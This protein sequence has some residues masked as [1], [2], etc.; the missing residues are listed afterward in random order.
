MEA[1]LDGRGVRENPDVLRQILEQ[2]PVGIWTMSPDGMVLDCNPTFLRMM[3][4]TREQLLGFNVLEK[5]V[6]R[7]IV[8]FLLRALAG[9]Q[10]TTEIKYTST[11]GNRTGFY[12]CL[13][14]PILMS[15]KVS[16]V[17]SIVEDISDRERAE[18]AL[19]E[20]EAR[21]RALFES[22]HAGIVILD[23]ARIEEFNAQVSELLGRSSPGLDGGDFFSL[24]P[25]FQEN[26]GESRHLGAQIILRAYAGTPQN[27]EWRF[28]TGT[29]E[30]VPFEISLNRFSTSRGV[31][32]LGIVREIRERKSAQR[33]LE[34]EKRVLASIAAGE[35]VGPVLSDLCLVIE[36]QRPHT[37]CAVLL[38]SGN[39]LLV[40]AAPSLPE[41]YRYSI[42]GMEIGPLAA[43]SGTAAFTK[44]TVIA[45]DIDAHPAWR[46]HKHQALPYGLKA[47]WSSPIFSKSGCVLGT[48]DVYCRAPRSPDRADLEIL[49]RASH[50]A[51]IAIEKQS[52]EKALLESEERLELALKGAGLGYWDWDSRTGQIG[53][54]SSTTFLPGYSSADLPKTIEEWKS[55]LHADDWER[56]EKT[57]FSYLAGRV[58][59]FDTEFRF[60]ARNNSWIWFQVRGKVFER[61]EEGRPLRAAGTFCDIS[62]RKTAEEQLF[63]TTFFDSLTG[64][65]NRALFLDRAGVCLK[66]RLLL[67]SYLYAVLFIDIDRFKN[68]N[69]GLGHLIGDQLIQEFARRLQP[70]LHPN[71]TLARLGGD[72]FAILLDG[73]SDESSAIRMAERIL[74][75]MNEP[76]FLGG[77]YLNVTASIGIALGEHHYQG[78][79]EVL[80]DADTAMYRA[81]DAGRDTY[82]VFNAEMHRYAIDRLNLENSLRRAL[83]RKQLRL[84]YQPVVSVLERA[85][86]GFE[87][88]I[89]WQLPERGLVPPSQFIPL[90]E[91]TGL[92]VPIGQ[93]VLE[94]ACRQIR[95]LDS[96][97]PSGRKLRIN[98]NLSARQIA[99]TGFVD[100]V[101]WILRDSAIDP[102]RICLEIT[103]SVLLDR[104]EWTVSVLNRLR[105]LGVRLALDDFGTGYASLSY[106][107]RYPV[108]ELKIDRSFVSTAD[109]NERASLIART[110]VLLAKNLG[111]SVCAEGVETDEQLDWVQNLGCDSVQG[112]LFSKPVP[113]EQALVFVRNCGPAL[114]SLF[115]GR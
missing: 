75:S 107:V 13:L 112:F 20:S 31:R 39:R 93:W 30:S 104:P 2:A 95:I 60:R 21:Y 88:L 12:R 83:E 7:A 25:P 82:A 6:D 100:H 103:E 18:A 53:V 34:A 37:L 36:G 57:F 110:I 26:A 78:P 15:G 115:G 71:D 41:P 106:L 61:D 90:A 27:F 24:S 79:E 63:R 28:L 108:S 51:A 81:K 35:P 96:S 70:L 59:L 76:F 73:I 45:G 99:Q 68:V 114:E 65:P 44:T 101:A 86:V 5:A 87:A 10:V 17:L 67:S 69:D 109:T 85:V 19:K 23:G 84:F 50:L 97:L 14:Q 40:G 1:V 42:H 9:E 66:R 62:S 113:E 3:G 38:L 56:T 32:L 16:F 22:A 8:P 52:S 11:T 102:N 92:I 55:F 74:G 80:R 111:L 46:D 47:C 91:D 72:E 77:N 29:G 4:S 89:R 58:E 49:A 48:L 98:V 54:S 105:S 94:E 33:L 43:S 64:L